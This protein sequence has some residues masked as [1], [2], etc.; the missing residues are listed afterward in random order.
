M[1]KQ[2]HTVNHERNN[3]GAAP[4]LGG[5]GR[6]STDAP[7][8]LGPS[9]HKQ[10]DRTEEQRGGPRR[11]PRGPHGGM[12]VQ[13]AKDA[14]ATLMRLTRYLFAYKW[15]LVLVVV[16]V[17]IASGLSVLGPFLMGQA[18]D[19][20]I[21][22]ADLSGLARL[23]I[24]MIVIYLLASTMAWMQTY[25]MAAASQQTIRDLREQLFGKMQTFSLRFFDRHTHGELMS[26]LSNDVDNISMVLTNAVT[27]LV[28][29]ALSILGVGVM[30]FVINW[31]LALV[32]L[33]IIPLMALLTRA[34]SKKTRKGFREQQA[35][36]GNLNG[37][38]EE[39]VTGHRVV[40]GYARE[41][42]EIALF[43][44]NNE[45][46]KGASTTAQ[47]FSG[48]MGPMMNLV[49]N[50]NFA[51]VAGVGGWMAV[52]GLAT[53]GTI[54]SFINYARQFSRP[55]DQLAQLY[56][57][58]QS[59]LAGAERV[60]EIF[61]EEPEI[62][63]APD[64][65]PLETVVGDVVFENVEFS[66][67]SEVPVLK[68][69]SLHAEPGQTIALVGPTGA[70]KTTIVSLLTRFYDIDRGR[71]LID[72]HDIRE[73]KMDDLRRHLGIVLQDTFLF[74]VSVMENIRYGRLDA[75][76]AEV[77]EAARLAN[78]D[79][80]IRRLPEGYK[81]KLSENGSNLSQGQRQL[82]SI[83]RAILADPG[84]LVLDEATSSVDTRTEQHIQEAMLRLMEGRTSFVI[85][86]RLSTVRKAD[87]IL[88]INEG[89][90]V[91]RGTHEALMAAQGFYY[92]LHMTQF[93]GEA[94]AALETA[95]ATV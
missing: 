73:I 1:G 81:T 85:A 52:Q 64:A 79:E 9:L 16:F 93:R 41:E 18:I 61:D 80:F 59:A 94:A 56:N 48:L 90:I 83:A 53:V 20:Y 26:R 55:L 82:L 8:G 49:N 27:Q 71:V 51:I 65:I 74:G 32:T 19:V 91:E 95:P 15:A 7:L 37:L 69:V 45:K 67:E 38:I 44:V 33:T 22:E 47:I 46:L 66:Y 57:Q 13:K 42:A 92:D 87:C 6:G 17:A 70:G 34:V 40:Q 4:S 23:V 75:T 25:V 60:F 58:I 10:P 3:G 35:Y 36:L 77:V 89:E 63:D 2:A 43:V 72:G 84:I 54:A 29:S 21:L 11:G 78:A 76:D 30:M 39:T 50:L 5:N 14:R 31:R 68:N 86:H 88:V 12:P 62:Q 24:L 28:S